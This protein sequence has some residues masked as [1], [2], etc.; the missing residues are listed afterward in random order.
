[1]VEQRVHEVIGLGRLD[2][3]VGGDA[4][5]AVDGAAGV[6][7]LD[8]LIGVVGGQ[9]VGVVVVVVE[10]D[11]VVVALDEAA[12][13]RVVVVGGQRQAGVSERL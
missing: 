13:W 3:F 6:G 2:L 9:R 11:A 5:A 10:R 12:G 7:E 4:A 1:L 8:F